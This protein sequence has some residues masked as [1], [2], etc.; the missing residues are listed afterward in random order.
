MQWTSFGCGQ[1]FWQH[2]NAIAVNAVVT[3]H[4]PVY[5]YSAAGGT[6]NRQAARTRWT[7]THTRWAVDH[8][9]Q[10]VESPDRVYSLH[11]GTIL[12]SEYLNRSS[13]TSS[14][15]VFFESSAFRSLREFSTGRARHEKRSGTVKGLLLGVC[16]V[17][18]GPIRRNTFGR[19]TQS[20][21]YQSEGFEVYFQMHRLKDEMT[22][23]P[24]ITCIMIVN[25]CKVHKC[26][27]SQ[28]AF[29][30]YK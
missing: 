18:E 7:V 30:A 6:V 23:R 25:L 8:S 1:I 12:H 2:N 5:L 20:R 24:M 10:E 3:S 29:C 9:A 21:S 17:A 4:L 26:N 22:N 28:A 14:G 11:G 16:F 27:S 13:T 15:K 19:L